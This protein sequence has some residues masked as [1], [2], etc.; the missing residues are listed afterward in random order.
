M[1]VAL[2]QNERTDKAGKPVLRKS[3]TLQKSYR[4]QDGDWIRSE[5]NLFPSEIHAVIALLNK[6]YELCTVTEEEVSDTSS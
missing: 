5:L 1:T 4:N 3:M 2:W 6:G